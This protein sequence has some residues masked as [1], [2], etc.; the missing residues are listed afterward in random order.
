VDVAGVVAE[1]A[2]VEDDF[3]RDRVPLVW[4]LA[5]ACFPLLPDFMSALD[6]RRKLLRKEGIT[7]DAGLRNRA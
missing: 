2:N 6:L 3:L 4:P 1:D 5:S 7:E